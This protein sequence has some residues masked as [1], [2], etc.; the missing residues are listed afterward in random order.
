MISETLESSKGLPIYRDELDVFFMDEQSDR[1]FIETEED[2]FAAYEM[3]ATLTPPIL[4]L[5]VS[6]KWKTGKTI[7]PW[8]D[9]V[10]DSESEE[11]EEEVIKI[12]ESEQEKKMIIRDG[13]V[14]DWE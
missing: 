11:D 7:L 8:E 6:V 10:S 9:K 3:A 4:K 14:F 2:L 13:L 1:C 5:C 12:R